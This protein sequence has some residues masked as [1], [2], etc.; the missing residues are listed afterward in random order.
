[1]K[2]STKLFL[3][4]LQLKHILVEYIF[5]S[6]INTKVLRTQNYYLMNLTSWIFTR[7]LF[8]M[9]LY[10]Q[11]IDISNVLFWLVKNC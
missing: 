3:F 5:R 8:E 7:I 2:L 9:K 4:I 10:K 11:L 1:M 6:G